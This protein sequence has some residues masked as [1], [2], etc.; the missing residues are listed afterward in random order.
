MLLEVHQTTLTEGGCYLQAE[1]L[2]LA[3]VACDKAVR[4]ADIQRLQEEPAALK[5]SPTPVISAGHKAE[6]AD[7]A[8]S[9]Y[10]LAR[11][12]VQID[13]VRAFGL[14]ARQM[15]PHR[16][17][18]LHTQ[19]ISAMVKEDAAQEPGPCLL[20]KWVTYPAS[21][22]HGPW[23]TFW[24]EAREYYG[25]RGLRH[26]SACRQRDQDARYMAQAKLSEKRECLAA[27]HLQKFIQW[28]YRPIVLN[29]ERVFRFRQTA[30]ELGLLVPTSAPADVLEEL[31]HSRRWRDTVRLQLEEAQTLLDTAEIEYAK[32]YKRAAIAHFNGTDSAPEVQKAQQEWMDKHLDMEAPLRRL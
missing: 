8:G 4:A 23:V 10:A 25:Y 28:L 22:A 14:T 16:A 29:N 2:K 20:R 13:M 6:A 11:C 3:G 26:E 21:N 1:P 32:V 18:P 30:V 24:I 15:D 9:V 12:E 27:H 17:N 7:A 5:F 31:D 19:L